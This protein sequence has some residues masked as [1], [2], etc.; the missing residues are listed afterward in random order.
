M[1]A[2]QSDAWAGEHY[3]ERRA[4]GDRRRQAGLMAV[5]ARRAG[6]DGDRRSR[7]LSSSRVLRCRLL[8]LLRRAGY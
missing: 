1:A 6:V 4:R 7:R 8:A 2:E 3:G 5:R